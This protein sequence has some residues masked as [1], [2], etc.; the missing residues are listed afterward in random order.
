MEP[1]RSPEEDALSDDR[2]VLPDVLA[3]PPRVLMGPGPSDVPA[4]V[5]AA[6][7][8]PCIGH[9][10]PAFI[11]IMDENKAML[12]QVFGTSNAMTLPMSGTGSA[13]ME[14]LFVNLLEPGD[15]VLVGVNGVFGGRMCEVA[16]RCGATVDRVEAPWGQPLS[17]EAFR[18]AAAGREYKLLA[19]V[20]AETSTG[21]L[22]DLAGFRALC[23]ELGALLLADCVTSLGG[24]PVDLDAHGVDAAYSG[25][26]KCLSVPPGL[27]P[28]SLSERAMA[29]VQ[30]RPA[31]VQSWYLD[32]SLLASYWSGSKRAYHHTAPV[33]MNYALHAGLWLALA[34]GLEARFAR[35]RAHGAALAA[36]LEALGLTLPVA[37]AHRLPQLTLVEVPESVDEAA[38]RRRLLEEHGLEIGGGLGAFAG[39]AWRI[40]LMGASCSRQHVALCLAALQQALA[41]QGWEAPADPMAAALGAY[42][43]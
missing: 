26:Q 39:R 32:L 16:R 13:G 28:V 43:S 11:R 14:T 30:G 24:V 21:V 33:N 37:P 41:A 36:G 8:R 20:H 15:R 25:T 42:G 12:R 6:L 22:Q 17:V 40:G 23:D 19:L 5:L 31:P 3:P 29:V 7:S 2:F 35:H 4:E 10:D 9:L 27:A 1:P 34:E 18:E 38:V